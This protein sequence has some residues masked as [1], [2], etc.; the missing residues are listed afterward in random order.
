M[1]K[2]A[3]GRAR[4]NGR[5][6][7]AGGRAGLMGTL[8]ELD[9]YREAALMGVWIEDCRAAKGARRGGKGAERV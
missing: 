6:R 7:S 2:F 4:R 1:G 3:S 5:G 8:I 9:R